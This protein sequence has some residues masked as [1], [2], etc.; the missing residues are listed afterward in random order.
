MKK[1]L[2]SEDKLDLLRRNDRGCRWEALDQKRSCLLCD[3][4]F[5][6]RQV[7]VAKT[8]R[9]KPQLQCPTPGCMGTPREWVHP[10]NPLISEQAWKDWE[11]LLEGPGLKPRPGVR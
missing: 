5:S 9:G 3:R 2:L 10:G 4:T 6:G 11:R 1:V 7:L 8:G